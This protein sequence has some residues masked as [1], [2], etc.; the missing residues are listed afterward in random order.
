MAAFGSTESGASLGDILGAALKDSKPAAAAE[1]APKKKATKKKSD[2][3]A[4]E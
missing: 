3:A 2:E 1:E 4:S